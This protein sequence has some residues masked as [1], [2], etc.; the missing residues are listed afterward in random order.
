MKR[1]YIITLL[2]ALLL[3]SCTIYETE[4]I[5]DLRRPHAEVDLNT[6]DSTLVFVF[7]KKDTLIQIVELT[8][9]EAAN[10]SL[11]LLD[12]IPQGAYTIVAFYNSQDYLPYYMP[13]GASTIYDLLLTLGTE[14]EKLPQNDTLYFAH[15]TIEANWGEQEV[16]KIP[17]RETFYSL[18]V[19][20]ETEG[21]YDFWRDM[22]DFSIQFRNAP[23]KVNYM[24]E[25]V[26]RGITYEISDWLPTS[27]PAAQLKL[28]RFTDVQNVQLYVLLRGYAVGEP[29]V[30]SPSLFDIDPY[31]EFPISIDLN[32]KMDAQKISLSI[33]SWL[34]AEYQYTSIGG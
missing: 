11:L 2:L 12:S 16:Y 8:G 24:G 21:G 3:G 29:V 1:Q 14:D 15:D 7:N 31:S 34:V 28:P 20:I 4:E 22:D 5:L 26:G 10:D 32:L 25:W 19:N 18:N 27:T 17:K 6:S 13:I 9:L 33:N 30:I 23:S